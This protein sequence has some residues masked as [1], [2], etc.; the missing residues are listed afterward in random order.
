MG[1]F[2]QR[3]RQL[4]IYHITAEAFCCDKD[5]ISSFVISN[6][7]FINRIIPSTSRCAG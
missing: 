6:L 2:I 7:Y 5:N 1:Q 3:M 4:G